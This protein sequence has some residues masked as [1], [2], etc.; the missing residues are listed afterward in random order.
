MKSKNKKLIIV[1]RYLHVL[2][3]ISPHH[4]TGEKGYEQ[5]T[6][7]GFPILKQ[8]DNGKPVHIRAVYAE[9]D[10]QGKSV[11][12]IKPELFKVD[13]RRGPR[14]DYTHIVRSGLSSLNKRGKVEHVG[15]GHTGI[16]RITDAGQ[17]RLE[18]VK[19]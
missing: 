8:L 4:K 16:Y 11:L 12:Y 14:K 15:K 9:I 7:M 2:Q 18:E 3:G 19:P 13:G 17:I 1:G 5:T 6:A 10:S